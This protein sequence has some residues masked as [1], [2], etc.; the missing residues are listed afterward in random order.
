MFYYVTSHPLYDPIEIY[1]L[2]VIYGL[3]LVLSYHG[4]TFALHHLLLTL[5]ACQF[6]IH[7][8]FIIVLSFW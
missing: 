2:F 3:G 1:I 8:L 7:C 4:L 5:V 6:G